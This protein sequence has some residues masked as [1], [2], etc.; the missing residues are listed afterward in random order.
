MNIT[1]MSGSSSVA[2]RASLGHHDI[3]QQELERLLAQTVVGRQPV[4]EGGD[5]VAGRLQRLHEEAAHV[6]IVFGEK[7]LHWGM[8]WRAS[9]ICLFHK[10]GM[11]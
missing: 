2:R 1:L 8:A 5:I 7:D 9:R 4:V 10:A 6:V 3:G 11:R